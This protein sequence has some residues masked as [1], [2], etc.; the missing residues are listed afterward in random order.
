M[1]KSFDSDGTEDIYHG[2]NTKRARKTLPKNLFDNAGDKLDMLDSAAEL[3][4]LR[5]FPGNELEKL[6]GHENRWSI[7]INDQYRILF[8][9]IDGDEENVKETDYN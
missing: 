5:K 6:E 2:R 1:I 7:R 9:W 3:D 4:D 8:D